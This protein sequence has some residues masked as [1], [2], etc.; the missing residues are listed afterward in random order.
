MIPKREAM[1]IVLASETDRAGWWRAAVASREAGAA[2]DAVRWSVAGDEATLFDFGG[3]GPASAEACDA[4][5]EACPE[6]IATILLHRDRA[7]FDLAYRLFFRLARQPQLLSN[8][9]DADVARAHEMERAVRRDRHK[10]RAFVR[11]R[12]VETE[13]G[14]HYVAWFEPAHHIV[15]ENAPFFVRRFASMRW[16]I[17]TP[18]A[19]AHWDGSQLRLTGGVTRAEA[20]AG[21]AF[22][23]MWRAYY[24]AIF[25][26]A[27]VM[28]KAMQKE[29]PKKYWKNLPEA[30]LIPQLIEEAPQRAAR[31]IDSGPT[32]PRVARALQRRRD[33]DAQAEAAPHTLADLARALQVCTRC[34]LYEKATQ[35]VAGEGPAR[36]PLMLVGEQPGDEEDLEGRPFIGPAGRVLNAA[37]ERVGI[38]RADA[39]VTNAVKHFKY[40]PRGKQRL[41]K[42]PDAREIDR[43]RWWIGHEIALVRPRLIVAL[44]ATAA[45]SLLERPVT[46]T[47]ERGVVRPF[48]EARSLMITVHPSYLLR[49]RGEEEKRAEW[50][51]FLADLRV[52]QDYVQLGAG[53]G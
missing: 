7:R 22:E 28:T 38:A 29:M 17:L 26:P 47:R 19:S 50:S 27:R 30:D 23:E 52:A 2:P 24:R 37:L 41:H 39:Y 36:A 4:V 46:V 10:M 48:G 5:P 51:L 43:C 49:L 6:L 1:A 3:G 25:N 11:F 31:M 14:D 32:A 40:E 35:A 20:P 53:L 44:G 18:D 42:K 45:Q 15:A 9:A 33:E 21:D 16:S 13:A 12:R 34:P 8:R